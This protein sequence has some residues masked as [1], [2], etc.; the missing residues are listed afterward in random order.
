MMR[1]SVIAMLV[2]SVSLAACAERAA[3]PD[4]QATA[5]AAAESKAA[6]VPPPPDSPLAKVHKGMRMGQVA[7]ILGQP[8]DQNQYVTGKAFIPWYYGDDVSRV[9][10]HYKGVGRV[11]F[12][13]GG[14]FG[15]GGGEVEWV[16]YDPQE[17]GYRR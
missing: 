12:T 17:S 2:L 5:P 1:S 16:E 6:P 10:W 8:T 9:E 14:A 7:E 3:Q 13:G 11:Y 4:R 15:Q